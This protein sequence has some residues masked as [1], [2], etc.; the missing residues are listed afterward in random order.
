MTQP[1]FYAI[2]D[3]VSLI[4]PS[5]DWHGPAVAH[6]FRNFVLPSQ[7]SFPGFF[8]FLPRLYL[9]EAMSATYLRYAVDAVS[10]ANLALVNKAGE[11][12][13]LQ[14]RKA[15]GCALH[16]LSKALSSTIVTSTSAVL[17]TVYLLWQYCVSM[18][19]FLAPI[20]LGYLPCLLLEIKQT[21]VLT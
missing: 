16:H 5:T 15:Y 20:L 1:K 7:G 4:V 10:V 13:L 8:E 3:A 17:A 2:P 6:F 19:R 14:A 9:N 11:A 18:T 12:C 21:S